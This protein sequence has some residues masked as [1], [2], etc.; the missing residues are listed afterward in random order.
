VSSTCCRSLRT[1]RS[2]VF[3]RQFRNLYTC[4]GSR[5]VFVWVL[6]TKSPEIL[7]DFAGAEKEFSRDLE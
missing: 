1:D 6:P 4:I 2:T 5:S 7:A 3:K